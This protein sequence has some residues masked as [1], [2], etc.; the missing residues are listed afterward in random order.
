M[1]YKPFDPCFIPKRN[2][3][4]DEIAKYVTD[5]NN[6]NQKGI[7]GNV[8]ELYDSGELKKMYVEKGVFEYIDKSF[9]D[10][11]N[12]LTDD[13]FGNRIYS[14]SFYLGNS[15]FQDILNFNYILW[16]FY[17]GCYRDKILPEFYYSVMKKIHP[18]C[19]V[20]RTKEEI[21]DFVNQRMDLIGGRNYS[22]SVKLKDD[23]NFQNLAH[24]FLNNGEIDYLNN[25]QRGLHAEC[26]IYNYELACDNYVFW[27]AYFSD[28]SG[29]DM[30]VFNQMKNIEVPVEVKSLTENNSSV[31]ITLNELLTAKR[32]TL[33]NR[34]YYI[35]IVRY[36]DKKN[37]MANYP[38]GIQPYEYDDALYDNNY[39]LTSNFYEGKIIDDNLYF[40]DRHNN[41][42]VAGKDWTSDIY[43]K[44]I[45][46]NE[47]PELW[48]VDRDI[49][50]QKVLTR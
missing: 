41:C 26:K 21:I 45:K 22:T 1:L 34:K 44:I 50:K 35:C 47:H 8:W 12:F 4:L 3:S 43:A 9:C 5:L 37:F 13:G 16:P 30:A 14:K 36:Y 23:L 24:N 2:S 17:D 42:I 11:H 38:N 6:K 49:D 10:F 20:N 33:N 27:P 7:Y 48:N 28:G 46:V 15:N 39:Y 25:I 19:L 29:F 32:I 18:E 31:N 40:F